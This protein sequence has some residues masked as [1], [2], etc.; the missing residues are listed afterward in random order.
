MMSNVHPLRKVLSA[1]LLAFVLVQSFFFVCSLVA[2]FG[3]YPSV[4]LQHHKELHQIS[5]VSPRL[6]LFCRA[7]VC[8]A[9]VFD[10]ELKWS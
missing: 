5:Q 7:E 3:N 4:F 6:D 8:E 1:C 9:G 10:M 2:L